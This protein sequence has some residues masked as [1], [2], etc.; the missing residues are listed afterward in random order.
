[1]STK[2]ERAKVRAKLL[3][4]YWGDAVMEGYYPAV[5]FAEHQRARRDA[6]E[7][8]M[9]VGLAAGL[10]LADRATDSREGNDV[11]R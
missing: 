11:P 3:E 7:H 2:K 5:R 8:G 1:M 10:R 9:K 6:W 4:K